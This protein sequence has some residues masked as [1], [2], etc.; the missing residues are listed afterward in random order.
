M[1]GLEVE[2]SKPQHSVITITPS[3]LSVVVVLTISVLMYRDEIQ[4]KVRRNVVVLTIMFSCIGMKY[5]YRM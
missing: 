2:F 5:N 3:S 4:I 1:G